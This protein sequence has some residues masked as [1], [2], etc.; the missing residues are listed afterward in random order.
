MEREKEKFMSIGRNRESPQ[1]DAINKAIAFAY[2]NFRELKERQVVVNVQDCSAKRVISR[3]AVAGP[4][5]AIDTILP[6]EEWEVIIPL[7]V[8]SSVL[9]VSISRYHDGSLEVTNYQSRPL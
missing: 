6:D 5:E 8:F 3:Q 7:K 9:I 4:G 2:E 1:S